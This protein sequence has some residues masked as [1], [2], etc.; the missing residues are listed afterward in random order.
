MSRRPDRRPIRR[1]LLVCAVMLVVWLSLRWPAVGSVVATVSISILVVLFVFL[2]IVV[3]AVAVLYRRARAEVLRFPV[4]ASRSASRRWAGV[5]PPLFD[6]HSGKPDTDD[7]VAFWGRLMQL[8]ERFGAAVGPEYLQAA[9]DQGRILAACGHLAYIY[10]QG[11][12]SDEVRSVHRNLDRE[13]NRMA[14]A[15]NLDYTV[16]N[17]RNLRRLAGGSF[18]PRWRDW[19]N[20]AAQMGVSPVVLSSAR[21]LLLNRRWREAATVYYKL[22][23]LTLE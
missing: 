3:L 7:S 6:F 23:V 20:L 12:R 8:A 2:V 17:V 10:V 19:K 9:L 1:I 16:A 14:D 11:P 18:S 15:G 22:I 5:L 21:L 4:P 13:I